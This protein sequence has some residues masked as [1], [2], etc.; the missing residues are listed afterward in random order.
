MV[1]VKLRAR[2][3]QLPQSISQWL[4]LLNIR[5]QIRTNSSHLRLLLILSSWCSDSVSDL[6]RH[7]NKLHSECV[8]SHP[9]IFNDS[10]IHPSI[11]PFIHSFTQNSRA[12]SFNTAG[13]KTCNRTASSNTSV[14]PSGLYLTV[15]R[16]LDFT[17]P[18]R[19]FFVLRT[20]VINFA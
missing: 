19:L 11:H 14:T 18:D 2:H 15:Q 1:K 13:L 10:F 8:L 20:R 7:G 9:F 6:T 16:L 3:E 17:V 4:M 12:F 5:I